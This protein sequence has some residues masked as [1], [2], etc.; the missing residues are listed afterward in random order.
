MI[1]MRELENV[2]KLMDL[3][4]N[5]TKWEWRFGETPKFTN[6]IEKKFDWALM[7]FEFDVEKG[8]IIKGKVYSDCLVPQYIDEINAIIETGDISYDMHGIEEL[9]HRLLMKFSDN[10]TITQKFIPEMVMWL[11]AEI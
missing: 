1:T 10:E 2:P 4:E 8:R 9:G 3:Y 6:Q 11:K 5:Y 7:D